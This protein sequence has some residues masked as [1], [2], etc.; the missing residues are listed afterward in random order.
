MS[1]DEKTEDY[2]DDPKDVEGEIAFEAGTNK[3]KYF[4]QGKW[5]YDY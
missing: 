1:E 4:Y 2:Y 3:I 5:N